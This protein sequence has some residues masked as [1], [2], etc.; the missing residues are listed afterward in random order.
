MVAVKIAAVSSRQMALV[1]ATRCAWNM[2]TVARTKRLYAMRQK[3]RKTAACLARCRALGTVIFALKER[4][5]ALAAIGRVTQQMVR[6]RAH[7]GTSARLRP[8]VSQA[9]LPPFARTARSA[10]PTAFGCALEATA[11]TLAR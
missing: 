8:V 6:H 2:A 10:V 3:K 1:G 9:R 4:A 5:A 11:L 7:Q